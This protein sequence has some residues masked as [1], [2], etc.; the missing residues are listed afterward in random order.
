V[1]SV[2]VKEVGGS[3]QYTRSGKLQ[4]AFSIRIIDQGDPASFNDMV[5]TT[6]SP[7][8]NEPRVG[9]LGREGVNMRLLESC[10]DEQLARM[11]RS[12]QRILCEYGQI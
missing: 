2:L 12:V 1:I 10:T 5:R 8:T 11:A 4:Q 6:F 9:L 7:Q 3:T